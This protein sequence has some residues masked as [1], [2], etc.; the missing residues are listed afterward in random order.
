MVRYL[1]GDWLQEVFRV[2][3]FTLIIVRVDRLAI[4]VK[5]EVRLIRWL[6]VLGYIGL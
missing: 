4:S 1:S 5:V 3:Y 6:S 2:V